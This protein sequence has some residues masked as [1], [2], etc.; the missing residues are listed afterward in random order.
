M[1]R[2]MSKP[3]F[4]RGVSPRPQKSK[5]IKRKIGQKIETAGSDGVHKKTKRARFEKFI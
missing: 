5:K 3:F 2:K 1:A 4:V